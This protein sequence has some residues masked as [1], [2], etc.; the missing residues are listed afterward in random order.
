M[1]EK[2]KDIEICDSCGASVYPEHL[3]SGKAAVMG[4][5]LLCTHCLV[6]YKKTHHTEDTGF[7]GQSTIRSPAEVA[8]VEAVGLVDEDASQASQIRAGGD[9]L[10]GSAAQLVDDIH[11]KRP[12]DPKAPAA[13][14]CRTF[15]AKLN[16][17][18]VAYMNN[19]VN[20]WVD[21]N[22]NI[23]IKSS[24]T[25]IGVWEA[26]KADPHMIVTVFY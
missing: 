14:R 18:A 2:D 3:E 16:D 4:G 13:T 6:E 25:T 22:P 9:T 15:H 20:E 17:G 1:P 8:E 12:L 21:Q 26:K 7:V 5:K 19:Q 24:S 11:Y 23:T 10:A